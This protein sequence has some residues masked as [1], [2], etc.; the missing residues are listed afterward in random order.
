[1]LATAIFVAGSDTLAATSVKLVQ[2]G[3][4]PIKRLLR[5]EASVGVDGEERGLIEFL[6]SLG[7]SPAESGYV[8]IKEA[9]E[10]AT[11]VDAAAT[12]HLERLERLENLKKKPLHEWL[13]GD[14]MKAAEDISELNK[15]SQGPPNL[16]QFLL[17]EYNAEDILRYLKVKAANKETYDYEST[18]IYY[19]QVGV[20]KAMEQ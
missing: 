17:D 19:L 2:A 9:E 5:S 16:L 8:R 13:E 10:A 15:S 4:A 7:K 14:L 12:S 18:I 20:T 11:I 6:K 1:M 3:D